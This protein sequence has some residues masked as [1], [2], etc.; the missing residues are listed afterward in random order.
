MYQRLACP[1]CSLARIDIIPQDPFLFPWT[2]RECIDP[3]GFAKDEEILEVL[4]AVSETPWII[5]RGIRKKH[6]RPW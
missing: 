5:S 3:F 6:Y 1:I 2:L 4:Q